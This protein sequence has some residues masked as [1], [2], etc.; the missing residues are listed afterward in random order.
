[1]KIKLVQSNYDKETG[2]S[3]A[4]INTDYGIFSGSA[5]LHQEDKH[6]E[7]SFAGCCYAETR[8][9][10]KYMKYRLKL[11]NEQIKAL[12]NCKKVLENKKTYNHNSTENRTI[13]KQIYILNKQKLEWK[14]K[15]NSLSN[16][17]L[18]NMNQRDKFIQA[19]KKKGENK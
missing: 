11:V 14:K 2:I 15:I 3:I 1:M 4:T 19:L 18:E 7:S 9:I 8:A 13:R 12:E 10:L 5:K 17:L 6:I 16:R